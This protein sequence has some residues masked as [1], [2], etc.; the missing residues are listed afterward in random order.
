MLSRFLSILSLLSLVK[1]FRFCTAFTCYSLLS[2]VR[3]L[4]FA[5]LLSLTC[6]LLL[7]LLVFLLATFTLVC[8]RSPLCL[9][10]SNLPLYNS[11]LS[12]ARLLFLACLLAFAHYLAFAFSLLWL[13]SLLS[14]MFGFV[15]PTRLLGSL[16]WCLLI[17]RFAF[18][19]WVSL[20]QC[21]VFPHK[22]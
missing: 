12:L 18:T 13:F 11:M 3:L 14:R 17:T 4:L 22:D 9:F 10:C 8:F 5:R 16:A 19:C 21:F 6:F 7:T 20:T 15:R 2:Q 1:F